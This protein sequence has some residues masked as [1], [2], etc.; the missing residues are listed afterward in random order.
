VLLDTG[1][2]TLYR[3]ELHCPSYTCQL[4][5]DFGLLAMSRRTLPEASG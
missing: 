5:T 1:E 3:A 4:R 2:V